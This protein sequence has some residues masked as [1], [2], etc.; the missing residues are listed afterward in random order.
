MSVPISRTLTT[1][2]FLK[3]FALILMV[4][5]HLGEYFFPE[6]IWLRVAGRLSF[7]V[8]LFL[9]GYAST[10]T[11]P[12]SWMVG[13]AIL[14][15]A[16]YVTGMGMFPLNILVTI[17]LCRWGIDKVMGPVMAGKRSLWIVSLVLL[18]LAIPTYPLVEYGTLAL[19]VAIFGYLVR[20]KDNPKVTPNVI[21][22]FTAFTILSYAVIQQLT[23]GFDTIQTV[24]VIVGMIPLCFYLI[25]MTPREYPE[26]TQAMPAPVSGVIKLMGRRTFEFYVI[27][28]VIFKLL[29]VYLGIEGGWFEW[30]WLPG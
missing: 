3:S 30:H 21:Y 10:R 24:A 5:D 28:L 13:A 19:I 25:R 6:Q 17:L 16:S 1:L 2:D 22:G 27:H 4:V 8:W 29:S 14:F 26:L 7:P 23:F 9:V 12:K 11:I 15:V 18:L 20:H